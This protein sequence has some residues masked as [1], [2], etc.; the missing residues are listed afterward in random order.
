MKQ[1]S[2]N[3]NEAAFF[4]VLWCSGLLRKKRKR[5]NRRVVSL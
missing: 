4:E 3:P 1:V 5:R 2:K